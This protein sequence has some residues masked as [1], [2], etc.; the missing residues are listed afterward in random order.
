[1]K[2]P[3]PERTLMPGA[4]KKFNLMPALPYSDE[5]LAVIA[6]Y[7]FEESMEKPGWYEKHY[8]AEHGSKKK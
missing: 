8:E 3:S 2:S 6:E 1:V 4:V 5:D 7:I